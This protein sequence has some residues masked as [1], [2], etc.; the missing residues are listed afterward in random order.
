MLGLT[1]DLVDFDRFNKIL[2]D[3]DRLTKSRCWS[4]KLFWQK[5]TMMIKIQ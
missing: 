4:S 1:I 2:V 3:F 5:L